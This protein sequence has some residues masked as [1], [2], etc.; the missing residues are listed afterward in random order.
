MS[1]YKSVKD[2]TEELEYWIRLATFEHEPL[3][4]SLLF[5]LHNKSKDPTY[6]G[7]PENPT[8]LYQAILNKQPIINRLVRKNVLKPKQVD[9]LLPPNGNQTF[10]EKFDITLIKI[11]IEDFTTLQAPT[12][13]WRGQP[14][15]ND[16][17][18][19]DFV[20]RALE[21]RNFLNHAAAKKIDLIHFNQRWQLGCSIIQ[22]L[23]YTTYNTNFLKSIPLDP[24]HD[25]VLKSL[26]S[27][28]ANLKLDQDNQLHLVQRLRKYA[29]DTFDD[30]ADQIDEIADDQQDLQHQV[31]DNHEKLAERIDEMADDQQDLQQQVNENHDQL[32]ER[33]DEMTDDQQDL[34]QQVNDNHDQLAERIDEMTDDQQDLQQQVNDNHDQF[35]ERINEI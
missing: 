24:K 31:N 13:G 30:L 34:Q 17:R 6:Q 25:V 15:P 19:A 20:V 14:R 10:S 5:V 12:R 23:G 26:H 35:A 3:R 9:L 22:G 29:D 18:L 7:L 27:L 21:W 33:I 4:E 11:L 28:M 2:A 16:K 8:L 1:T 32:A